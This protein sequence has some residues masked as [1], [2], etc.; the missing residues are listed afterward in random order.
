MKD[1]LKTEVQII[2]AFVDSGKG[3]NP[4]GVVLNADSL[5]NEQKLS[6]AKKV[7]LSETA[8]VSKSNV[9]DFKLDFFT[10]TM[11]I[12]HCGH[13]TIATFSYLSQQNLI[14]GELSSKETI[15]G[16]REILIQGEFAFMEQKAPSYSDVGSQNEQI[17]KSLDLTE[18]DILTNA[19]IALVNTGN[20]FVIIPVKSAEVLKRIQ[21]NLDLITEISE[22][23][24]L[25]G[26]YIFSTETSHPERDATTRMFAPRYGIE[27]EAATGMA[28]GPIACYLYNKLEIRKNRF[29]IEQGWYMKEPSPSLIIVVLTLDEENHITR[30]LAGGKGIP[31]KIIIV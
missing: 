26:Y 22:K 16:T 30:I 15:D 10:P 12:A 14:S 5:T 18:D 13:A 6:I 20:S 21:P 24:N 9:A 3:G 11:Q 19:P 27:E 8:F 23:L 29:L 28:A 17:L 1:L 7:G 25:I 2:N 4:A 31:N